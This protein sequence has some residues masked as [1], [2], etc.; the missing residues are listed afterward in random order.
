MT[1]AGAREPSFRDILV[2]PERMTGQAQIS[3]SAQLCVNAAAAAHHGSPFCPFPL[4]SAT[5]AGAAPW[6]VPTSI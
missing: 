4:A 1:G 6:T 5:H 2:R 3:D